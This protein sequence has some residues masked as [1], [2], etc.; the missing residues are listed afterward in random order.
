MAFRKFTHFLG[1]QG[2][3]D[4]EALDIYY[5]T[6][7]NLNETVQELSLAGKDTLLP[8]VTELSHQLNNIESYLESTLQSLEETTLPEI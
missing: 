4:Q 6:T 8:M 3:W 5:T 1:N 7:Q 2:L